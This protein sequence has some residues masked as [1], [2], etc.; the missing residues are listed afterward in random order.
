M[1]RLLSLTRAARLVDVPRG[2]LQLLIAR[3]TLPSFDGLIDLDDLQRSFPDMALHAKLDE[4]GMLEKVDHIREHSFA[5]R[6][7]E[8]AL[9]SQE[10]L[11]QRLF[12]LSVELAGVQRHLQAYHALV[13]ALRARIVGD[14]AP[15]HPSERLQ[16]FLDRELQCILASEMDAIDEAA[17]MLEAVSAHVTVRPS[18]HQFLVEGNDTLLQAG[19][20]SGLNLG[21][22][23]GTGSC[24]LCK[25]RVVSGDVRAIAHSDYR[26]SEQERQQGVCLLCTHTAVSDVIIETLEANGPQDI[27]QQSIVARVRALTAMAPDTLLLHLQTPRTHRLRFL[28]GQSVTLGF[29]G[30][31]GDASES[32]ALASCPCDERNLH[33]HV[34]CEHDGALTG[35]LTQELVRVGDSIDVRGP[36]GDFVLAHDGPCSPVFL[37]CDTAFGPVKSLLEH[38][39]AADEYATLAL[40]WLS[41]RSGGHYMANLCRAWAASLDT[42]KAVLHSDPDARAGAR[43]LVARLLTDR[44]DLAHARIFVA[45]PE[46]FVAAVSEA[47]ARDSLRPARV[48]SF[49]NANQ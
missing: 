44:R 11:A 12:R 46:A 28:A 35:L 39:M 8:I 40:Y 17:R 27:P 15:V 23:C 26:L 47:L 14:S 48:L 33:F 32:F 1:P 4:T 38:A 36:F 29:S 10:V 41:T 2:T 31:H 5:R 19:L 49:A 6:M 24:G 37:A 45:G 20:K 9:P 16:E 43:Q 22:G 25:A 13:L 18:G 42:F 3:G 21:Y 34:A 30:P 7:R